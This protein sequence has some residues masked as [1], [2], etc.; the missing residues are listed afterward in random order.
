M[1]DQYNDSLGVC[2][3]KIKKIFTGAKTGHIS[4]NLQVMTCSVKR[5]EL[6]FSK[7]LKLDGKESLDPKMSGFE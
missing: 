2:N 5:F 7:M 4:K 1:S 6:N 3:I